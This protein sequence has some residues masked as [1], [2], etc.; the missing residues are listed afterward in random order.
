MK[1]VLT[2][3]ALMSYVSTLLMVM[4]FLVGVTELI[5]QVVKKL[6]AKVPTNFVAFGV[7]ILVTLLAL[8]IWAAVAGFA[9][10]WYYVAAAVILGIF[11]AYGAM[12]GFDKLKEAF[13]KWKLRK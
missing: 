5:V 7:A 8:F 11:V 2:Y 9:V 1:I 3:E 4:A 10:L 13:A 6:F 12:F